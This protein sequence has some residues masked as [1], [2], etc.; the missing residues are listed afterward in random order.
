MKRP[1]LPLAVRW[2]NRVAP[3]LAVSRSGRL[4]PDALLKTAREQT[5]LDDLGVCQNELMDALKVL[6]HSLET[7][8]ELNFVGRIIARKHLID[9]LASRL[10]VQARRIREPSVRSEILPPLIITGLPRSGSSFLQA[11]LAQDP[12]NRA[13]LVWETMASRLPENENQRHRLIASAKRQL[14]WFHWL[15][16]E[17][18]SMHELEAE[19]PQE[20]IALM[21]LSFISP[22]FC[23]LYWIPGYRSWLDQQSL[24]PAYV[25]HRTY[26]EEIQGEIPADCWVLKAPEH[27]ARIHELLRVYP[28]AM[29]VQT[30]REPLQVLGSV[31]NLTATLRRATSDQQDPF[32]IG[33][34]ITDQ[35]VAA[36]EKGM[37][38]R[39]ALND[40]KRFFD[41]YFEDLTEFPV[42]TAARI[43]DYFGL[44]FTRSARKAMQQFVD[45]HARDRR[46]PHHYRLE[47]FGIDPASQS[48]R[49]DGYRKR[50]DLPEK[51]AHLLI[52]DIG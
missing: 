46:P 41:V 1:R 30:H 13:P 20:C 7:E 27:L 32:A 21:G 19:M 4:D 36:L 23:D 50:F 48:V 8:A 28:N 40:E 45:D 49:F 10:H 34:E 18:R 42:D 14:R 51:A 44:P 39:D 25:W 6:T 3:R 11:V 26:L 5:G 22:V 16:P 33:E 9:L 43:Y 52:S 15:L 12:A 29:V 37:A 17:L 35:N 31:A 2:F 24:H 47:D 38:A